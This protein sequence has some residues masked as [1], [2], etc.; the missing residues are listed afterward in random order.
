MTASLYQ[1]A[2]SGSAPESAA[3]SAAIWTSFIGGRAYE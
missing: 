1:S 3:G 2:S